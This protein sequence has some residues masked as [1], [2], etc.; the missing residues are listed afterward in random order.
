VCS[1]AI[2][3]YYSR[4]RDTRAH[5]VNDDAAHIG[6]SRLCLNTQRHNK[7]NKCRGE[8]F[9]WEFKEAHNAGLS[10][11]ARDQHHGRKEDTSEMLSRRL[12]I[13]ARFV[14]GVNDLR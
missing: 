10:A 6:A 4:S 9:C 1:R 11:A 8:I 3:D 7:Q 14:P 12:K 2:G 5:L 13:V